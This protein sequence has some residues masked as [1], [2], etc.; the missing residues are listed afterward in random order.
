MPDEPLRLPH[1]YHLNEVSDPD[2]VTLRR[3]DGSMVA[4]FSAFGSDPSEIRRA[5]EEDA[6]R[7]DQRG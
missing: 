6:Q 2:V 5:A 4:R 7:G 3:P 1:G